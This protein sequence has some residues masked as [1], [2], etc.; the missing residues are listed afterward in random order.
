MADI[1]V[2]LHAAGWAEPGQGEAVHV[3]LQRHAVLQP[4]ADGGGQAVHHAAQRRALPRQGDVD[5]P[6][7]AVG[8]LAGADVDAV[9]ADRGLLRV[10]PAAR[11]QFPA[12]RR[13]H[14][15]CAG[16]RA[17][18]HGVHEWRDGVVHRLMRRQPRRRQDRIAREQPGERGLG[19]HALRREP[20]QRRAGQHAAGAYGGEARRD[21]AGVRAQKRVGGTRRQDRRAGQVRR[22]AQRGRARVERRGGQRRH[23]GL[24]R[25]H[26]PTRQARQQVGLIAGERQV[27][28]AAQQGGDAARHVPRRRA[29]VIEPQQRQQPVEVGEPQGKMRGVGRAEPQGGGGGRHRVG[30]PS[31]VEPVRAVVEGRK[32]QH[33]AWR[34]ADAAMPNRR[35]RRRLPMQQQRMKAVGQG[36]VASLPRTGRDGSDP[37][38]RGPRQDDAAL[39]RGQGRKRARRPV[40]PGGR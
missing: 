20:G 31:G 40:V 36:G 22:A 13:L 10:A 14:R 25:R 23:G 9:A 7:G 19:R 26:R 33:E 1:R 17:G 30:E 18:R 27:C 11:R 39:A 8:I 32:V 4:Q 35:G 34:R 37:G 38:I 24:R 21:A 6:Q 2:A 5:L 15:H 16:H 3:V 12:A 28:C 29:V